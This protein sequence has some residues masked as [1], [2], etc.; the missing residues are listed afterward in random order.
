MNRTYRRVRL[1]ICDTYIVNILLAVQDVAD[2][3]DCTIRSISAGTPQELGKAENAEGKLR[4]MAR[5]TFAAAVHLDP[6]KYCGFVDKW[7]YGSIMCYQAK[8]MVHHL[9]S[10]AKA[11]APS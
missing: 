11:D 8:T 4:R 2:E 7:N 10:Y 3:P 5:A 9:T 6:E 1:I